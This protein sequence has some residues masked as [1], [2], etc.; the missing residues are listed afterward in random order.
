[1]LRFSKSRAIGLVAAVLAIGGVGANAA[2]PPPT[3]EK[4]IEQLASR[5]F[6][7]RE[8]ATKALRDRG[9]AALPALRKAR[10]SKDEEVRK[11]IEVLIPPLEIDEALLPRRVTLR[12]DGQPVSSVLSDLGKQT[13]FKLTADG[14]DDGKKVTAELK[15]VPFWEAMEKVLQESGR[16]L[17]FQDHD[18]S[19]RLA[20][21][22]GHSRFVN[23]RGPFRLEA[24][25]FHEDRDINFIKAPKGAEGQR[26]NRLTLA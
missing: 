17:T 12:A 5:S 7:E 10:E 20:T 24:T 23:V 8:Q 25:W 26:T 9:P 14:K 19:L 15:D 18:R 1:M 2:D 11:R 3:V 16:G 13:D 6:A 22:S 21:W 4:L